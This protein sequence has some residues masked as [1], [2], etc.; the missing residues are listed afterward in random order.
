MENVH[1]PTGTVYRVSG[2]PVPIF[3]SR[4]HYHFFLPFL[5]TLTN[6]FVPLGLGDIHP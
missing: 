3:P 5:W 1:N 4:H 6:A 2:G